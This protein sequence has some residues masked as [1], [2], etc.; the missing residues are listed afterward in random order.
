V[1]Y[2]SMAS[3]G[4]QDVKAKAYEAEGEKILNKRSL[5]GGLLG[6]GQTQASSR[7]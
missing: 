2:S 1:L 4:G 7:L 6:G 3:F 5:L